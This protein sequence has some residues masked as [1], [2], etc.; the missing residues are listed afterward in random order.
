V[1]LHMPSLHF[2]L[3]SVPENSFHPCI[4]GQPCRVQRNKQGGEG[5]L[6]PVHRVLAWF[7]LSA[8]HNSYLTAGFLGLV[9]SL[10]VIENS[11]KDGIPTSAQ[12]VSWRDILVI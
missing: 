11:R 3:P 4:S 1:K 12:P 2:S 7:F 8:R 9:G 6:P 5:L 10:P